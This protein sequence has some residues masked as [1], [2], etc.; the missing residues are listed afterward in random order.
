MASSLIA[1]HASLALFDLAR[2]AFG[3]F[4]Y[5]LAAP[6]QRFK[7]SSSPHLHRII[8]HS[9]RLSQCKALSRCVRPLFSSFSLQMDTISFERCRETVS[10]PLTR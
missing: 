2:L 8:I 9:H 7:R 5:L 6:L 10:K 1:E 3:K 4:H